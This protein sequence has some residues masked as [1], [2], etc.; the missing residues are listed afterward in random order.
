MT[1]EERNE[2][3]AVTEEFEE[4]RRQG[5]TLEEIGLSRARTAEKVGVAEELD[6]VETEKGGVRH[7]EEA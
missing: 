6:R 5:T 7:V 2:E 3:A 1:Q 4:L